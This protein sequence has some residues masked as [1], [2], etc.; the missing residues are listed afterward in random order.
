MIH[1]KNYQTEKDL[2]SHPGIKISPLGK[3][4]LSV[5]SV[6]IATKERDRFGRKT[7]LF[8]FQSLL[9]CTGV[10]TVYNRFF[11]DTGTC[12]L[13]F[14]IAFTGASFTSSGSLTP[15]LSILRPTV[16]DGA[17]RV[18][19]CFTIFMSWAIVL[20]FGNLACLR[21]RSVCTFFK[22]SS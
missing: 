12:G 6:K 2:V 3:T 13:I 20:S 5:F 19:S 11:S 15:L 16:F 7:K 8:Q 18:L 22:A 14:L 9:F 21:S 1:Q 10:F 17:M 4:I